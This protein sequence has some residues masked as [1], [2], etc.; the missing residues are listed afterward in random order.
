MA[1]GLVQHTPETG[2]M[3]RTAKIGSQWIRERR[4]EERKGGYEVEEVKK[5]MDL[6]EEGEGLNMIKVCCMKFSRYRSQTGKLACL[7]M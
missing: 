1:P 6:G 3:A 2:S 7:H 4:E 5:G